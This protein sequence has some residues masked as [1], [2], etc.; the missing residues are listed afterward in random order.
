MKNLDASPSQSSSP[1]LVDT[2]PVAFVEGAGSV[3]IADGINREI[4][5][6]TRPDFFQPGDI[7]AVH[8][9]DGSVFIGTVSVAGLRNLVFD[10]PLTTAVKSGAAIVRLNSTAIV[11][12]ALITTFLGSDTTTSGGTVTDTFNI[13]PATSYIEVQTV[14]GGLVSLTITGVQSGVQ[15]LTPPPVAN[16]AFGGLF[17]SNPIQLMDTQVTISATSRVGNITTI[18]SFAV[19]PPYGSQNGTPLIS[20]GG[21]GQQGT[22]TPTSVVPPATSGTNFTIVA[23]NPKRRGL[24]IL[25]DITT[26]SIYLL[27]AS[28]AIV[29]LPVSGYW[30]MPSPVTTAAVQGQTRNINTGGNVFANEIT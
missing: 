28:G 10:S 7:L 22:W 16:P 4:G 14:G 24:T 6:V 8:N 9:L 26:G 23:A 17:K 18:E 30:E 20:S 3:W 21:V 25:A 1:L 2:T 19:S 15:Y 11:Q 5:D 27:L 13:P 12:N 29:I